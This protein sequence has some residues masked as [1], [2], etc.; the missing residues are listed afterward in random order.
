MVFIYLKKN[1]FAIFMTLRQPNDEKYERMIQS[2][3]K[4]QNTEALNITSSAP[5]MTH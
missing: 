5:K 4:M 3:K 2:N 1:F